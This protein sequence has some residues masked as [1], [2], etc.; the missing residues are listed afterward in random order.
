MTYDP[1]QN[2]AY[3]TLSAYPVQTPVSAMQTSAINSQAAWNQPGVYPLTQPNQF[4]QPGYPGVQTYAGVNPQISQYYPQAAALWQNPLSQQQGYAQ[5]VAIQQLAAQQ[6]LAQQILA[7]QAAL[8]ALTVR[9]L[10]AQGFNPV[11]GF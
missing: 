4:T 8:Q 10:Q 6:Q 7:H 2:Q 11:A 1:Y 3:A 5:N 9:A